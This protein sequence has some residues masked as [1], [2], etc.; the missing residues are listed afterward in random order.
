MPRNLMRMRDPADSQNVTREAVLTLWVSEKPS[1][2]SGLAQ[3][4]LQLL[5]HRRLL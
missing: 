5:V 3:D 4:E 2:A 1:T